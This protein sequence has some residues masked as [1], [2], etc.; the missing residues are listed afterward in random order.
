M[1]GPLGRK[2]EATGSGGYFTTLGGK[3]LDP[4]AEVQTLGS[5]DM[6]EVVFNSRLGRCFGGMGKG[7]GFLVL[8]SE[9]ART[10]ARQT[11]GVRDTAV[12]DVGF[13]CA[14]M[15]AVSGRGTLLSSRNKGSGF[16]GQGGVGAGMS[17]VRLLGALGRDQTYVPGGNPTCWRATEAR[18]G[19]REG[20]VERWEPGAF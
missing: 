11:V 20:L 2:E 4:E 18:G 12:T 6:S 17:V 7:G 19:A 3:I 13:P 8:E 5:V 14:L 9:R 10:V 16:Q 15:V 1:L